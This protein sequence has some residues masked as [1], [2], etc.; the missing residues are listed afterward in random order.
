MTST[1]VLKTLAD[2]TCD[3]VK[4]YKQCAEKANDPAIKQALQRRGQQREQT[5]SMLNA[6]IARQGGEPVT[7]G[8]ISGGAHR[9]WTTITSAFEDNDEA[10]AE[11]VEEGEDYIAGKF[12]EALDNADLDPQSRQVVQQCAAEIQQGERFGDMLEQQHG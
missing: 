2:T 11:R 12:Q 7:D 3:S 6:E 10:V 8:T 5:L 4:G 9:I 1:N